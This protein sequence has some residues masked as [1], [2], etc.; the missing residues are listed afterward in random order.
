MFVQTYIWSVYKYTNAFTCH[1]VSN[2]VL[3]LWPRTLVLLQV[4]TVAHKQDTISYFFLVIDRY[5]QPKLA[6]WPRVCFST[7]L[8]DKWLWA[9]KIS[10]THRVPQGLEWVPGAVATLYFTKCIVLE[11]SWLEGITYSLNG[12]FPVCFWNVSF[13]KRR[14]RK[15]YSEINLRNATVHLFL[16]DHRVFS[17]WKTLTSPVAKGF[18]LILF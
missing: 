11:E 13:K 3:C 8:W 5:P 9:I 14:E 17:I 10:A 7:C 4:P 16:L 2:K 18:C 12:S 1:A 6:M 15:F